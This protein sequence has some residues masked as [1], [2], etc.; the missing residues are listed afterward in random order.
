MILVNGPVADKL[1]ISSGPG[2]LGPGWRANMA[3]G[4]ALRLALLNIGGGSPGDGDRATQGSPAKIAFC[5][6]ENQVESPWEPYHVEHGFGP[7]DSVVTVIACEGPHNIQDHFSI[8]GLGV[9][10]TVAARWARRAA[11]T[12]CPARASRWWRSGPSTPTRSR[13]RATRRPT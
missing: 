1:G 7:D 9:L 11:T 2:C 10:T 6:A 13:C 3:I 12:S 8:S 5:L 4:R